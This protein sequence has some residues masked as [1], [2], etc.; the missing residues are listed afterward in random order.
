MP[1]TVNPLKWIEGV[2]PGMWKALTEAEIDSICERILE[3]YHRHLEINNSPP[4]ATYD[5]E[6]STSNLLHQT[7]LPGLSKWASLQA[8]EK[9]LKEF[10][11]KKGGKAPP[12]H[13]LEKLAMLAEGLG[14]PQCDRSDI[15]LVQC[16]PSVRYDEPV[17]LLEAMEAH[18]AAIRLCGHIG[19]HYL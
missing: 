19:Q 17:S 15:S 18:Q 16:S 5:F 14:L 3:L 10:V 8:V 13:S 1:R 2:S 12:I 4:S 11:S 6:A 9:T 7:P